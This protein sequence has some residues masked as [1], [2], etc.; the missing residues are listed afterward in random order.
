MENNIERTIEKNTNENEINRRDFLYQLGAVAAASALPTS[1]FANPKPLFEISLAE[2]SLAGSLFTGKLKNMDFPAKA[3]NDFGINAVEYVSG[4]WEGKSQDQ[5]YLNELKQRTSDLGVRNVLIMVDSEG[6]LGASKKEERQK[7]VENHYKWVDAA[8]FLG[9]Y[10]IRVNLEGDGTPDEILKAGVE[11][12]GKLVE[13]GAKAGIS[14]IIENH[15]SVSTNPDWLVKLLKQVK[16][17]Y[18]GALPDFGNFTER[19]KPTAMT[20]EAYMN[21]KIL[22]EYDKYEGVKK[23]MPFA[24][25]VSAKTHTF[26]ANGNCTDVDFSKMMPIVKKGLSK[27]FKGFIGIEYEGG[28]MKVMGAKGDYL[29]EDAGIKATKALLEKAL[30]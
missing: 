26:D 8:K 7:A 25:G 21:A 19:E 18:A 28:V 6:N 27:K 1:V 4:F 13:Y 2:F 14:I 17:P 11:G 23:L 9:C 3:K 24:Q 20:L 15:I 29:D 12:Y 5:T 16:S 22:N 30:N 10:A